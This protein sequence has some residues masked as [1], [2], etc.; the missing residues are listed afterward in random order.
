MGK[1]IDKLDLL[2]L[3]TQMNDEL[4]RQIKDL[5]KLKVNWASN[6]NVLRTIIHDLKRTGLI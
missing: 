3:L 5:E 4:F 1:A 2:D 6:Q